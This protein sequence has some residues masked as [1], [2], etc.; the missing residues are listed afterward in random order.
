MSV[1]YHIVVC[2]GI[3][4]DPLQTLE[5]VQ[6]PAG[7]ALK[8]EMMLPAVLDTWASTALYNAFHLA[9][10]HS[11]TR[12]WLVSAAPRAKL[13]QV[14][15][16]VGQKG[17]FELIPIDC[18]ASGFVDSYELGE[19]LADTIKGIHGLNT[20]RLL[21]FG[22]WESGSRSSGTTLQV[23]AEK[24]EIRDV[25]MGV[26]ELQVLGDGAIEVLERVEGGKHL[27]SRCSAPPIVVGWATGNLPEPPNNPQIGMQNMRWI[28]PALQKAKIA[29]LTTRELKVLEA[30][31]P[32]Q[33]RDTR[34][35]RD[36]TPD[37]IAQ[38]L[39]EWILKK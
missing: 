2:A 35:V 24:L 34:V 5:P 19:L 20:N 12:V 27:R 1:G 15:M 6:G 3:V 14:L 30:S 37:Q 33:L 31:L 10:Q 32:T 28:M 16:S 11:G 21:I 7:F 22:G 25:F 29:S 38:E 17:S 4:P 36:M 26:D 13:Q 23:I 39:V 8:N 9:K 18:Q